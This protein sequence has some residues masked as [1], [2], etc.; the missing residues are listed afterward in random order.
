LTNYGIGENGDSNS[1]RKNGWMEPC[2]A[3]REKNDSG[4]I[5]FGAS[6]AT[7]QESTVVPIG[8]N[9][10]KKFLNMKSLKLKVWKLLKHV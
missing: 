2:L 5:D 9:Q 3:W 7:G 6:L 1:R 8:A 10:T 4:I